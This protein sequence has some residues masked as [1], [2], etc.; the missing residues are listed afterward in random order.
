DRSMAED[1]G[2]RSVATHCLNA[3]LI[4]FVL[5]LAMERLARRFGFVD[6]PT[7]RKRHEGSVPL[8]GLAIFLAFT[9]S[10][11]LVAQR[12]PGI[13]GF[14]A[15]LSMIVFIGLV[16]DRMDLRASYKLL[17]QIVIV[18]VIASFNDLLIAS[19]GNLAHG[20]PLMLGQWALPMT[21]FAVVGMI[22][23]IN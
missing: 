6:V 2:L 1:A 5:S 10:S 18:S 20:Q 12:P 14:L 15:G 8:V 13:V 9:I 4:S 19:A 17:A 23:A 11:L 22:N 7:M 16:D 21:V 3:F